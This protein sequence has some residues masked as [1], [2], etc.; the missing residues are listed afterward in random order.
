MTS[1]GKM[2]ALALACTMA[3]AVLFQPV[4][5]GRLRQIKRLIEAPS[6]LSE[7]AE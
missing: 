5:M 3:A 7:A 1:I 6:Q 4:R 2:T